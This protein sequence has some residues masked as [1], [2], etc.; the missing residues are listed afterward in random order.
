[1][2]KC[3]K[4]CSSSR[5]I[6]TRGVYSNKYRDRGKVAPPPEVPMGGGAKLKTFGV[7]NIRLKILEGTHTI[8]GVRGHLFRGGAQIAREGG[9]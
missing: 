5:R 1:M 3:G 9:D 2:V 4:M 6:Q 7:L 8:R